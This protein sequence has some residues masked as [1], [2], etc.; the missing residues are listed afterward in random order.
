MRENLFLQIGKLSMC[1]LS[2]IVSRE[3]I[4]PKEQL[5]MGRMLASQHHR[6]PDNS[7]FKVVSE[8]VILGHNRL[9]I[10]DL[11]TAANQ[12][13]TTPD[14]RYS[15]VF[16]GE[17]YNYKELADKL[18]NIDLKTDSDTEVLL[19]HLVIRGEQG[20]D[21]LNGMFAFAFFDN[22][23]SRLLLVRDRFGV[24]PLH[25]SY[26][27][28]DNKFIFASEIKA[29]HAYGVSKQ[30][31]KEMWSNYLSRGAY[32]LGEATFWDNIMQVEAGCYLAVNTGAAAIVE[33]KRWFNFVG[34]I[35]E[36]QHSHEFS[37]A[38][39]QDHEAKY[40]ALMEDSMMLRFRSDVEVG[41]TVSGGV[42]SSVLLGSI[43]KLRPNDSLKAFTFYTGDSRYDEIP[44]VENLISRTKANWHKV[45]VTPKI[46][47]DS[48]AQ[49]FTAQDEPFG[50]IPTI[51][52]SQIFKAARDLNIKVLLDG[53]GMDE[54]WAGYDYYH[55]QSSSIV[56]GTHSS[57]TRPHVL[58]PNF[59]ALSKTNNYPEPFDN[60]VLNKQFR[61]L[62]YTKLPRALRFN[63]RAS[64]MHSTELREPFLDYRL[65]CYAFAQ[66]LEHKVNDHQT[67]WILRRL[68]KQLMSQKIAL[69]PKRALQ[70]PQRE[71][72]A[73]PLL[74]WAEEKIS[75]LAE[76]P[77]IDTKE[78]NSQWRQFVKHGDDN[79]FYI[80]QWI[81]LACMLEN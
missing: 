62:F 65:V 16:N 48:V 69:A 11:S 32:S 27:P 59:R 15:L 79:T 35:A 74:G 31:N 5:A 21:M 24:K 43:L 18:T 71:W 17:I 39:L 36:L 45:L 44:W 3:I 8:N 72:L 56:Q 77:W 63:D 78:L 1:G 64:M 20:L 53:Q 33:N 67:K 37:S 12:P 25:Y 68:A 2:G 34:H 46:I 75:S 55:R 70:T 28:A 42:D 76:L 40:S 9:S 54:A 6:G 51:A 14:G 26:D 47:L 58:D 49:Q 38:T 19:H 81:S 61:D 60:E 41:V 10:I 13:M 66:P 7:D 30:P 22:L 50:G 57:P 4:D 73:G 80:W 29:L 23:T 52:Y